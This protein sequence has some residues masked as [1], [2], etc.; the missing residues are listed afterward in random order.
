MARARYT[1]QDVLVIFG[2]EGY[3]VLSTER[4]LLND[5]GF[6]YATTKIEVKCPLGHITNTININNFKNR[7]RCR[8]CAD[9]KLGKNKAFAYEE[10][11]NYIESFNYILLSTE[12][13]NANEYIVVQPPCGHEAYP[14]TFGKFKDGN[15]CPKC[16]GKRISEAQRTP[17]QEVKEYIENEGYELLSKEYKDANSPLI[18]KCPNGHITSTMTF[19]NFKANHRCSECV[20][21]TKYEQNY[22][23]KYIERYNYELLS[24]EYK[25]ANS[26]LTIKCPE[27]HITN[28]ITFSRFKQGHRCKKCADIELSKIK[29]HSFD[30]IKEYVESFGYKLLSTEYK[31]SNNYISLRCP[32]G[33]IYDTGTFSSFQQG[34]RCTHC[35]R[36][37]NGEQKIMDYLNKF[38]IKFIHDK[39]YFKDLLTKNNKPLRPDFIIEDKKIWIEFD[40]GQHYKI[41][42]YFGGLMELINIKYKD[43]MKNKYSKENGWKLIRI[44][45]WDYDRI[46]EILDRELK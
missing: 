22:V 2:N 32:L 7:K 4:E 45:Y 33:H 43:E 3:E 30:Y 16:K 42:D 10:V 40:G 29:M 17:Y 44:P 1:Y 28:T 34:C 15:R 6:I 38:N 5:K 19:G 11:K 46:E 12:Y 18:I 21:N 8:K 20:E 41:V 9:E 39:G 31:G 24:K 36:I 26:P 25:G 13:K 14:V 37:S 35:N 27:G 23:E